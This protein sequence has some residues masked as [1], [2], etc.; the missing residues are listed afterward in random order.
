MN[1]ANNTTPAIDTAATATSTG[2]TIL[3]RTVGKSPRPIHDDGQQQQPL[4]PSIAPTVDSGNQP[5]GA[6]RGR[7]SPYPSPNQ[8]TTDHAPVCHPLPQPDLNTSTPSDRSRQGGVAP[9][10]LGESGLLY[11]FSQDQ[12]DNEDGVP[13]S[14]HASG[15]FNATVDVPS[16]GLQE[17]YGETYY[18]YCYTWCPILEKDCLYGDP[19]F[20]ESPLLQNSLALVGSQIRPPVLNHESPHVYYERAK[21]LFHSSQERN[22]LVC[23]SALMLFYWWG[24]GAPNVV[25]TD[26]VWWWTGVTI[27]LAQQ[28]GLH[29]ELKPGQQSTLNMSP[30]L[31]R[32]IWWTLFARERLTGI[33][34]GRPC[35]IDPEDCDIGEPTV[36]DFPNPHDPN[37]TLFVYWVRLCRILGR[38]TKYLPQ[39]TESSSFPVQLATELV[40]WV[41][42]LPPHLQL[43]IST[44]RTLHFNRDVHQLHLPYLTTVTLLYLR[45]ASQSL[46]EAYTAAVVASGCVARIFEDYLARG[47]IRFLQGVAGWSA[48]VAILALLHARKVPNLTKSADAHIRVLRLALKEMTLLWHSA[49]MF[50]RGF[51]RMLG[52]HGHGQNKDVDSVAL[53]AMDTQQP[54]TI[55]TDLPNDAGVDWMGFF[56]YATQD[57]SPLVAILLMSDQPVPLS[58]LEWPV[59]LTAQLQ[60]LFDPNYGM[61]SFAFPL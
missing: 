46:P 58:D 37:S 55:L 4:P 31:R 18:E 49:K 29:H 50:D 44:E 23:I 14:P 48:A 43:P 21:A 61:D 24:K 57:T 1:A 20:R 40:Q 52:N 26:T 16:L 7:A 56:P 36:H 12:G 27:R 6:F 15:S 51:E 34:Q 41:N 30:G 32:R 22:P 9:S 19:A 25:S 28:I 59:D 5:V 10:Y 8:L 60:E 17:S 2:D 11:I 39:R 53:S 38:V 45:T 42:S 33:C 35:I 13:R 47:S 54:V 3:S